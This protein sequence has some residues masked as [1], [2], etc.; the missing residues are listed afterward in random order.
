M[1]YSL[2]LI[3]IWTQTMEMT[4]MTSVNIYDITQAE[5]LFL[6]NCSKYNILWV[7]NLWVPPL[8]L[9]HVQI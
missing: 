8:V 3:N 5:V 9:I 6:S 7:K 1:G 4:I 2:S